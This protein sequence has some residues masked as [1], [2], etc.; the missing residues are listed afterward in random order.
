MSEN[1]VEI[2]ND[3]FDKEVKQ[4]KGKVILDFWASWC[5]P[6]RMVTPIIEEIADERKDIKVGKVNTDNNDVLA[7]QFGIRSIPT[8]V[9]L[10][11]GEEYAREVGAL[12]KEQLIKKIDNG[13]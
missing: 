5:G 6:C 10:I 9:Y 11:D 12:P 13:L 2:T 8:I 1:T 4:Y 7:T 3:N